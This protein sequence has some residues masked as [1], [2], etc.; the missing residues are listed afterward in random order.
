M[1]II[2]RNKTPFPGL[3]SSSP[4]A[5]PLLLGPLLLGSLLLGPLLLDPLLL[6]PLLLNSGFGS[7]LERLS[8]NIGGRFLCLNSLL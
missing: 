8:K 4:L 2:L 5:R 7:N 3:Q 1:P 6:G